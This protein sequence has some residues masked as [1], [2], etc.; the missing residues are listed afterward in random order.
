MRSDKEQLG[1]RVTPLVRCARC[2]PAIRRHCH[3]NCLCVALCIHVNLL[4]P[5]TFSVV[6]FRIR[7]SPMHPLHLSDFYYEREKN[8]L[9]MGRDLSSG[10]GTSPVGR[11]SNFV[12]FG[13]RLMPQR[14]TA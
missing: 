11:V 12:P 3:V 6:R 1:A 13:G 8:V 9:G 2:L 4:H 7:H 10:L 5:V 14:L